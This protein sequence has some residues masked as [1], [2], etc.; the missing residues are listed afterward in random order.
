MISRR[1]SCSPVNNP[2]LNMVKIEVR[3]GQWVSP[4]PASSDATL[5]GHMGTV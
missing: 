1:L 5:V 4:D 2:R 3:T